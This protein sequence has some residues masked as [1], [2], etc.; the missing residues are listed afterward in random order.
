VI[1]DAFR[2]NQIMF[3]DIV[4]LGDNA[5]A[6][7]V[8]AAVTLL[9]STRIAAILKSGDTICADGVQVRLIAKSWPVP[10]PCCAVFTG[11][12]IANKV[13]A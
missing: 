9:S 6:I 1:D 4:L 10:K 12:H 5:L 8:P 11:Q 13:R 3:A 7:G 2:I